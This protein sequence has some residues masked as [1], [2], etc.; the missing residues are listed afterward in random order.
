MAKIKVA[1]GTIPNAPDAGFVYIYPK[2]DKK[3][4]IKDENGVESS[5]IDPANHLLLNGNIDPDSSVGSDGDFYINT[6]SNTLFGPKLS[7]AWGAG[8]SIVGPTGPQGIQ[9]IQGIQGPQCIQGIQ[10]PQGIQGIQGD[11]TYATNVDGGSASSIYGGLL[12]Q[13]DG[14][15]A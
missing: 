2:S 13:V 14:G 4:Y 6:A 5:L 3:L 8:A 9:G 1:I 12:T 7:G 11:T 10:G 15:G